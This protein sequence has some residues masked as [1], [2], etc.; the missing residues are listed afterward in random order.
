MRAYR[1]AMR[2]L[3]VHESIART[4]LAAGQTTIFGLLGDG[5]M[6]YCANYMNLGGRF[7]GAIHEGN[8][9]SMADGF[10]RETDRV[11]VVSVTHGPAVTNT[12]TA[13]TEAVRAGSPVLLLS[14]D[15]PERRDFVQHL[16]L[17]AAA[18]LAG[19][20]YRRVLRPEHVVDD[21]AMALQHVETAR[22]PMIL[23]VPHALLNEQIDDEPA[24]FTGPGPM[25]PAPH[26]D[27]LDVAV[28]I[29][30][31]AQRPVVLAGAGAVRA[32]AYDELVALAERLGAPLATTLLAK[33]Y[34][35]GVPGHIGVCGTVSHDIGVEVLAAADCLVVFGASLNQYTAAHG[36][37]VRGKSIVHCDVDPRALGRHVPVDAGI[38]G[39]V[40]CTAAAIRRMLEE[41]DIAPRGFNSESLQRRLAQRDPRTEFTDASGEGTLDMRTAMIELD[42]QLPPSRSVITD[43]GRFMGAPWKYLHVGGEGRFHHTVNFGSIGLGLSTAIGAAVA[44]RA[45]LTVAVVGDGGVAMSYMELA[46]AA[47][48]QLPLVVVVLDDGCY[49]AEY[50]KLAEAGLNPEYSLLN[51]PNLCEVA[52]SLGCR[53]VRATSGEELEGIAKYVERKQLPLLIDIQADPRVDPGVLNG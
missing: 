53:A 22:V 10:A 4:L 25:P 51:S 45:E 52:R 42:A 18:S 40:G 20:S 13:L 43:T 16:D 14:G 39:D 36:D 8:A 19:A 6:Q 38:V 31:T 5:N 35:A 41:A 27:A 30:A 34:F 24:S 3:T 49:G 9:V 32:H 47:R 37:L 7:I 23:D 12:L 44:D 29:L 50:T 11:S 26:E 17:R 28:G 33:D 21:V 1:R 48:E 46:T 2:T 15:T